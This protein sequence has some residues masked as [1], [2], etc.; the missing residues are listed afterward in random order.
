MAAPAARDGVGGGAGPAGPSGPPGRLA[1]RAR[2]PGRRLPPAEPRSRYGDC[3]VHRERGRLGMGRGD[4]LAQARHG[5]LPLR[6]DEG[7]PAGRRDG[8]GRGRRVRSA[9]LRASEVHRPQ[10]RRLGGSGRRPGRGPAGRKD[11]AVR[12]LSRLLTDASAPWTPAG[13]SIEQSSSY[14][15]FNVELWGQVV[16]VLS[17]HGVAAASVARVRGLVARAERVSAWL[18]EPDGRL[19]VLGDSEARPGVPPPP[20]TARTF[21]DDGAGLIVGRWSWTDPTTTY[22]TI[23]YGPPRIAQGNRSGRAS[24][25]LREDS[26]SSSGPA[27]RRSTPPAAFARG[28]RAPRPTTCRPWTA[29]RSTSGPG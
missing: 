13:T 4:G 28:A 10:P 22:Y 16:G 27:R 18:T 20:R 12:S 21:R 9:L 5:G 6:G 8:G 26:A 24:P 7:P 19:V 25:G 14:H 3:G 2:R 11:W 29:G 15:L 17:A 23:R 1:P